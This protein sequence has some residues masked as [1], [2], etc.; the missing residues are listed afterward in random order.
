MFLV[1]IWPRFCGS[2]DNDEGMKKATNPNSYAGEVSKS[3]ST[4]SKI[5]EKAAGSASRKRA[6]RLGLRAFIE[7]I[8]P[9]YVGGFIDGEGSFPVSIGKHK[10]LKRK[11]EVRPSLKLEVRADDRPI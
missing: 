2:I 9:Y 8:N 1:V 4:K 7:R 6:P 3:R 11:Y 5:R 10:T